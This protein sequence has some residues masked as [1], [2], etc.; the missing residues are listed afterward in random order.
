LELEVAK[1]PFEVLGEGMYCKRLIA[2]TD[3][4]LFGIAPPGKTH[5][6]EPLIE[7]HAA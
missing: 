2:E 3:Q 6:I 1:V 5:G 4:A 7:H